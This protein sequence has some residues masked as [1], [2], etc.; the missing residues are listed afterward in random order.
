MTRRNYLDDI[1]FEDCKNNYEKY[2]GKN[3]SYWQGLAD[4]YQYESRDAIRGAWRREAKRRGYNKSS[5]IDN[6]TGGPKILIFDL[7][8]TPMEGYFW[9]LWPNNG[10]S[11]DAITRDWHLL[12]YAAKWLFSEE[13]FS[14]VLTPKEVE[15]RDD[16]RL[17]KS[18]WKLLDDCDIAVAFN[19]VSFDFKRCNTRFLKHGL[20]PPSYYVPV[21]PILTAKK[22]F[23]IASN[24]MDYIS[25]FIDGD[26]K[27]HTEYS[28]WIRCLNGEE[29]ALEDMETYNKQD[30]TVL[31]TI[32]LNFLP[33]M[34]GHPNMNVFYSD[35]V[36]RCPQCASTDIVFSGKTYPTLTN[37]Y[38]SYRCSNCGYNGRER[39][40]ILSKEKSKTIL[41]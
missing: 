41:R 38:R 27:I 24:K 7:E 4:K 26:R 33:W 28:L 36:S 8:N 25:E 13:T 29:S 12:S 18:L 37:L 11:T 1:I 17:A 9:N 3:V 39:K 10:I 35:D 20:T 14:E 15:K 23:D 6:K 34:Q 30:V 21:D 16:S 2:M 32:Y 5:K 22:T 19:G 40:G 31:E